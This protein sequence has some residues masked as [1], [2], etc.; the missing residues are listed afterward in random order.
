M[1]HSI[2]SAIEE[3]P[4]SFVYNSYYNLPQVVHQ[5]PYF[6]LYQPQKKQKLLGIAIFNSKILR[7]QTQ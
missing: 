6:I 2:V 4:H 1:R 5:Q 3:N 7:P